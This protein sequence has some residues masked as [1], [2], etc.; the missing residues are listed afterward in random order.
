MSYKQIQAALKE[1]VSALQDLHYPDG[2]RNRIIDNLVSCMTSALE[3]SWNKTALTRE[4]VKTTYADEI[5][6]TMDLYRNLRSE[7]RKVLRKDIV[8]CMSLDALA[9][10]YDY[11]LS[12]ETETSI[13]E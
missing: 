10:L 6:K 11:F 7:D 1:A 3:D 12:D 5:A 9:V 13:T 2:E 4:Y 8:N